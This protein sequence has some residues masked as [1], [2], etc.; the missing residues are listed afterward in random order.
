ML[1]LFRVNNSNCIF[2]FEVINISVNRDIDFHCLY[3]PINVFP[4]GAGEG[5]CGYHRD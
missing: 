1:K 3:A 5:V 2:L 4:R